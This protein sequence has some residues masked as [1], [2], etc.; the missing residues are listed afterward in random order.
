MKAI[1]QMLM[2]MLL[3]LI[4]FLPVWQKRYQ[5]KEA[6]SEWKKVMLQ[7]FCEEICTTGSCFATEWD[8]YQELLWAGENSYTL[9]MEAYLRFEDPYAGTHWELMDW[10]VIKETMLKEGNCSFDAPCAIELRAY[11]ERGEMIVA[12]GLLKER[13]QAYVWT[14]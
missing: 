5:E 7:R 13:E 10:S 9:C 12:G 2:L 3:L 4:L 14:K 6:L 1:H 11:S 8:R